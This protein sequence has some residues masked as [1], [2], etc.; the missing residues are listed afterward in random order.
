MAPVIKEEGGEIGQLGGT[1]WKPM[2]LTGVFLGEG[3][4]CASFDLRFFRVCSGEQ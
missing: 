2:T 3:A 4:R 1:Q